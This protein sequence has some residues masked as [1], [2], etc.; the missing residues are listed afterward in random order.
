MDNKS[1]NPE[2]DVEQALIKKALGYDIEEVTEEYACDEKT[3][4]AILVKKKKTTKQ[5]PPDLSAIKI[6]LSYYGNKTFDELN[7]LSDEELMQERDN[8]LQELK[9]FENK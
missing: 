6:L 2:F 3:K 7:S 1:C 4:E 5:V 9:S 8:L